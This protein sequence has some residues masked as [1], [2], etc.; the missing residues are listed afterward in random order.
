MYQPGDEGVVGHPMRQPLFTGAK[1]E[2]LRIC[3][4]L[5]VDIELVAQQAT[6]CPAQGG[7]VCVA[8]EVL[9]DPFPQGALTVGG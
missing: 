7:A 9:P 1:I 5:Q 6:E 4:R 3:F 8:V 2:P